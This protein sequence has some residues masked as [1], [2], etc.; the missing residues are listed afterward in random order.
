ML[1]SMERCASI[2]Q[3]KEKTVDV[4]K[5]HLGNC[6]TEEQYI[7]IEGVRGVSIFANPAKKPTEIIPSVF[8]KI[9]IL[10]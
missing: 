3:G 8:Q 2:A 4:A 5:L 10:K 1:W 6:F 7:V 9:Q